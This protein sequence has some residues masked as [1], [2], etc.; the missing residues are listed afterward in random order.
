MALKTLLYVEDN[1]ANMD[2][3]A[4]LIARRPDI[5]LLGAADGMRGIEL[6][7]KHHPDVILMDINLPGM[8]GV[9]CME[10]LKARMPQIQFIMLTVYED[11]ER[12]FHALK[13]ALGERAWVAA[14]AR[15][16]AMPAQPIFGID[17]QDKLFYNDPRFEPVPGS[18]NPWHHVS[19]PRSSRGTIVAASSGDA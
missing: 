12:L 15:G 11:S 16:V 9:E 19:S 5:R 8:S 2:L 6:A 18:E 7:R 13:Q 3:V 10:R 14:Y 4:Q 17:N 1:K